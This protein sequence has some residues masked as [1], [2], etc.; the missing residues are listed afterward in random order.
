MSDEE[1]T[2]AGINPNDRFDYFRVSNG[3]SNLKRRSG[4]SEW[5]QLTSEYLQNGPWYEPGG[6]SVGVVMDWEWPNEAALTE[7]VTP[8]QLDT[9]KNRIRLG[10][11]KAHKAAEDWA[12]K[13]VAEVLDL[14]VT[15]RVIKNRVEKTMAALVK[16]GHFQVIK[17]R[18]PK[19]R[20]DKDYFE[21]IEV[22][23]P[24][25]SGAGKVLH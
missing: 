1:A 20:E 8:T 15:D 19:K 13:I 12:G 5:R 7:A 2:K 21:V 22:P 9:I 24:E 3:K 10:N 6:D 16:E 4:Q 17:R 25:P 23:H 11:Y 14:D 18:D